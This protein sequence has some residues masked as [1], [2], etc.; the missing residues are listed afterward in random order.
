MELREITEIMEIIKNDFA[1]R[2]ST[3]THLP[4][5]VTVSLY[6]RAIIRQFE[7]LEGEREE[8]WSKVRK[9]ENL[10][11]Q[12]SGE[13]KLE[14]HRKRL[15]SHQWAWSRDEIAKKMK[16]LGKQSV[17]LLELHASYVAD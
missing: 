3:G 2:D 5:K 11:E 4:Q 9:F 7:S 8:V 10:L 16:R 6:R 13:Q 15:Q 12:N 17:R 14:E 1:S